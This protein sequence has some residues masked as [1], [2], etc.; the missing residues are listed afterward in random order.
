MAEAGAWDMD[1]QLPVNP[2]GG[3]LCSNPI[4]ATALVRVCEA[5][6]QVMQEAGERQV[7]GAEVAVAT[8]IGGSLQFHTSMVVGADM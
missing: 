3:P 5:A 4:S 1:G 2:S 7:P 8:G 6:L